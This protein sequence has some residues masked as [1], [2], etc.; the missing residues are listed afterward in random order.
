[1]PGIF[2]FVVI[3]GLALVITIAILGHL[4]EKK[5]R[6]AFQA[7]AQR[8]GM[9]YIQRDDSIATRY[10]FLDA[11]RQGSN[12]YAFNVLIG[13]Y[14]GHAAQVFDYH[15][16]THST[17][18][19]GRRQTHHHHFSFFILALPRNFPELRI[20]PEG[21]L[22][23]FGQML[24][25]DDIDFE[26]VEFSRAFCVRST[27]KKFA[28]DICHTRM[29]EYLLGNRQLS[30]EIEGPCLAMSF[31]SRLDPQQI[32]SRLRQLVE[33]RNLFPEYLLRD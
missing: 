9:R 18:S 11:L 30:L 5:R 27:D 31:N 7:L 12:R 28:Y 14:E 32:P 13:D 1:M 16:E 22:S 17:D 15:Y 24:G 4:W 3:I 8:L 29:M 2:I 6:E 19:K 23:K 10:R 21:L 33:I 25:F 20:Y 26:S